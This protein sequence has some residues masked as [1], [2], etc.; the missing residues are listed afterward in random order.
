M[1]LTLEWLPGTYA[2]CRLAADSPVPAWASGPL[3]GNAP[4]LSITRTR[5]ELSIVIAEDR[6]PRAPG[7]PGAPGARMKV[8]P[9]FAAF[10]VVGTLD[11]SLTGVI[12]G[13]TAL[14]AEAGIPAFV[15]STHD[16][17]HVLVKAAHRA[18]AETSL[19]RSTLF[20]WFR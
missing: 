15:I 14:L 8:E 19:A 6:A 17:D 13:L 3:S 10:R 12:A 20:Q 4:F 11:F 16:T 2:V 7:S 5:D 18:R 9:G 1:K